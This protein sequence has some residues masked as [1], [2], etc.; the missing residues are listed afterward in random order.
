MRA[1]SRTAVASSSRSG[2]GAESSRSQAAHGQHRGSGLRG[3]DGAAS[4]HCGSV[5]EAEQL[6]HIVIAAGRVAA[7]DGDGLA[8]DEGRVG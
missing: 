1:V 7:V 6:H 8:G 5:G 4:G 2:V 3:V